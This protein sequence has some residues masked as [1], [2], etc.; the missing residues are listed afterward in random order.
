MNFQ[1]S[2][3]PR[4]E[5]RSLLGRFRGG[6]L[7][8]VMAVAV[9]GN[10]SGMLSQ[11]ITMELD[12]IAGRMI[13]PIFGEFIAVFVPV[14]A[15]E[16]LKYPENANAGLTDVIRQKLVSGNPLFVLENDNLLA[17][18]MEVIPR[19][20]GG[21]K[22]VGE[23]NRLAHNAAVNFLRQRKYVKATKLL[24]NST[25]ITPA[26]ITKTALELMNGVLDPDDHVNG[27]VDLDIPNMSLPV[28]GIGYVATNATATNVSVREGNGT[29][30]Y[31]QAY[32]VAGGQS[33][34]PVGQAH[35]HIKAKTAGPGANHD[36]N[37]QLNGAVAGSVSL[38]DFY[39][40]ETRDRLTR[41]MRKMVDDDPE[42]GE[43]AILRWAHGLLVD[44]ARIPFVI[45]E[46]RQEFG[47]G[48]ANAT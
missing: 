23:F 31:P 48:I 21:V 24:A 4:R 43:E 13:T 30:V 10:E 9:R 36:I 39:N 26:I 1:F 3:N 38:V 7:Q 35:L 37:A 47:R 40:A 8:P 46:G 44:N 19:S 12:P 29:A 14:Q 25:V 11:R 45:Y 18:A 42:Y 20:I 41:T 6:K 32:G 34:A 5:G 17:Q 16:A 15:M 28:T 2:R 22:K 27:S 33:A